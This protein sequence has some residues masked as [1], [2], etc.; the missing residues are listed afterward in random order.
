[1]DLNRTKNPSWRKRCIKTYILIHQRC[2]DLHLLLPPCYHNHYSHRPSTLAMVSLHSTS[3]SI[4]YICNG[5]FSHVWPP[6]ELVPLVFAPSLCKTASSQ[7][8]ESLQ[9]SHFYLTC[10]YVPTWAHHTWL[11]TC[12]KIVNTSLAKQYFVPINPVNFCC[13][14]STLQNGPLAIYCIPGTF[15]LIII[16]PLTYSLCCSKSGLRHLMKKGS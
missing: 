12:Q 2:I 13:G 16:L 8:H 3:R 5:S 4:I 11:R 9:P 6:T 7:S 15:K 1:M 10:Q 14:I